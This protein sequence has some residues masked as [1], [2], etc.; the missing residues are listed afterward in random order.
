VGR[1]DGAGLVGQNWTET[2]AGPRRGWI[3]ST[4]PAAVRSVTVTMVRDDGEP[5]DGIAEPA[6]DSFL[7]RAGQRVALTP[8][9]A[10][11]SA[12]G[13]PDGGLAGGVRL[14]YAVP[15][16]ELADEPGCVLVAPRP[17]WHQHGLSAEPAPDW[18]AS[19]P[20]Q[21]ATEVRLS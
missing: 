6:A 11:A 15:A 13:G 18:L 2:A 17:G 20:G 12:G 4:V 21:A 16:P 19:S 8:A 7:I 5:P 10:S 14:R 3:T 9:S 1:I